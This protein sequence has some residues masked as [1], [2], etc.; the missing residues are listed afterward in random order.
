MLRKEKYRDMNKYRETRNAQKLRYFRKT[1][2]GE[3]TGKK[4][5]RD[6][7][8][9]IMESRI[10]DTELAHSIG[11]SVGAI[12]TMRSKIKNGSIKMSDC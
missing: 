8:V 3:N 10:T 4:W 6:D 5:T 11:R 2:G 1:Q 7:I 9:M 12:Q